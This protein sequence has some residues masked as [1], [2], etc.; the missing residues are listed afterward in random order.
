MYTSAGGWLV[1]SSASIEDFWFG[2]ELTITGIV[3]VFFALVTV[4]LIVFGFQRINRVQEAAS[5]KK[6]TAAT[7]PQQTEPA[8]PAAEAAGAAEDGKVSPEVAAVIAAAVAAATTKK[9]RI[10]R[11]QYRSHV[12][13]LG[14][15]ETS[16]SRQGRV[17]IMT[18]RT[19]RR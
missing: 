4:A 16:W 1:Q 19:P 15:A 12:S 13:S 3:V 17:S 6:T 5:S 9:V 2:I 8:K 11:I 18:S 7:A 14:A 10:H